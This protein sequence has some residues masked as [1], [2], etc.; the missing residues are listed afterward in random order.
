ML[1]KHCGMFRATHRHISKSALHT[2][3]HQNIKYGRPVGHQQS[4]C[5][6][7]L[8]V[9]G[10]V[11]PQSSTNVHPSAKSSRGCRTTV[12]Y[13]YASSAR[14]LSVKVRVHWTHWNSTETL[15]KK[16]QPTTTNAMSDFWWFRKDYQ[17]ENTLGVSCQSA[18]PCVR[19]HMHLHAICMNENT[20]MSYKTELSRIN[21]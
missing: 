12:V 9:L 16:K 4:M 21:S 7:L 10:S 1:R 13:K 15:I 18:S 8:E 20:V 2:K 11:R 6:Q 3:C 19:G 14:S 5:I 17:C